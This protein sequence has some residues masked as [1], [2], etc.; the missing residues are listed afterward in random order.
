MN[1]V[2]A[3]EKLQKDGYTW[4]NLQELDETFYNQ[5]LELKSIEIKLLKNYRKWV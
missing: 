4:F 1:L 2:E 3:K 5:L